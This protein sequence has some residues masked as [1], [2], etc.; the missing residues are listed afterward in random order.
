[1]FCPPNKLYRD[2]DN[3]LASAKSGIDGVCAAL[4]IN[5]KNLRPIT[6]DWG[7]Q[8]TGGLIEIQLEPY[9]IDI[10]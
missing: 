10:T 5:D 6:L 7:K 4:G 3:T 2:L 9:E 8:I 1:M